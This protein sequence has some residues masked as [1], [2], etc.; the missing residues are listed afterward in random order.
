MIRAC[1]ARKSLAAAGSPGLRPTI[2]G[3]SSSCENSHAGGIDNADRA[4]LEQRARIDLDRDRRD[5]AV[6]IAFGGAREGP[7]VAR[8]DGQA[9][10]IDRDRDGRIVVSRAP[11]GV[12]QRPEIARRAPRERFAVRR[13]VLAQLV[14]GRSVHH[15]VLERLV[16]A[17][18]VN[19]H[20]VGNGSPGD[21]RRRFRQNPR[22]RRNRKPKR[23]FGRRTRSRS[24]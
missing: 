8:G 7:D 23:R 14:K 20:L 10:A 1:A 11:Q 22:A 6:A 15:R 12:D 2:R 17:C 13:G 4:E 24:P 18:D 16:A 21:W 3:G 9:G 19:R 5:R